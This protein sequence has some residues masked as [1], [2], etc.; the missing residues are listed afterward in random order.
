MRWMRSSS[1]C[2]EPNSTY[3]PTCTGIVILNAAGSSQESAGA[4]ETRS[5]NG[6]SA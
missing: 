6:T 4:P 2:T 3:G 5:V 1:V